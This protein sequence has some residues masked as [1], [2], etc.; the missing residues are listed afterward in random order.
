MKKKSIALIASGVLGIGAAAAGID[1]HENML[2]GTNTA[3]CSIYNFFSGFDKNDI[4]DIDVAIYMDSKLSKDERN[5]SMEAFE[6]ARQNYFAEFGI[7]LVPHKKSDV[8]APENTD[9]LRGI[10]SDREDFAVVF[11][12]RVK[13]NIKNVE[14]MAYRGDSIIAVNSSSSYEGCI[15]NTILHEIGHLFY[16]EH[17]DNPLCVMFHHQIC[18]RMDEWCDDEKAIITKYKHRFWW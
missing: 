16:A 4:V 18:F 6:K 7:N 11:V 13:N 3:Y 10:I 1:K 12:D 9:D 2:Y 8:T 14:G 17:S 15:E 5:E